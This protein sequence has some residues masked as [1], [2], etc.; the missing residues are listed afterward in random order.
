MSIE[1]GRFSIFI[2]PSIIIS[3]QEAPLA[4][5]ESA[6]AAVQSLTC[7]DSEQ[8][9][10]N[11]VIQAVGRRGEPPRLSFNISSYSTKSRT[12]DV[13]PLIFLGKELQNAGH[14]IRVATHSVFESSVKGAGLEFFP[15][16][17]SIEQSTPVS[18][19]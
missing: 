15:I 16:G 12:G 4:L 10:L 5:E 13:Q 18:A 2:D 19:S 1:N 14:N 7:P 17:D 3:E 9:L 8:P 11:I 6:V